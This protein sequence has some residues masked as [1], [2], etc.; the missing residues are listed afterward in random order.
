VSGISSE[1]LAQTA[2][3]ETPGGPFRILSAGSLIRVKGFALAIKAFKEFETRHPHCKFTIVGS[4]PEKPRLLAQLRRLQL[5]SKVELLESM[6]RDR[7]LVKMAASDAFL[8]PSLRDGGGTVV[9]EAMAVGTPVVCLDANG[10]GM[11][12]TQESGLKIFPSSP[13]KAVRELADA[14]E[15]LYLNQEMCTQMGKAARHRV[16]RD[17]HWDRLGERLM[18]IY[19]QALDPRTLMPVP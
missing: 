5:E 18:K 16:E 3:Q 12:I 8:F 6:P 17:Y 9:I 1:D 14:L 7:L 15:R 4:G 19:Q 13:Q 10:P 11:H 2:P